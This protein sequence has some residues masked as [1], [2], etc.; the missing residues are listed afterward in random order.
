MPSGGVPGNVPP[1][2]SASQPPPG[3]GAGRPTVGIPNTGQAGGY[4]PQRGHGSGPPMPDPSTADFQRPYTARMSNANFPAGMPPTSSC[5]AA[6]ASAAR[7]SGRAGDRSMRVANNNIAGLRSYGADARRQTRAGAGSPSVGAA[8]YAVGAYGGNPPSSPS[9]N[10]GRPFGLGGGQ[11]DHGPIGHGP[12]GAGEATARV[13]SLSKQVMALESQLSSAIYAAEAARRE[14]GEAKAREEGTARRL[15]A[16]EQQVD[17][18]TE[19]A[20]LAE[21]ARR[22]AHEA[23]VREETLA[24]RLA[25]VEAQVNEVRMARGPAPRVASQWGQTGPPPNAAS[26]QRQTVAAPSAAWQSGQPAAASTRAAW[27]ARQPGGEASASWQAEPMALGRSAAANS[28]A[29]WQAKQQA[30]QAAQAELAAWSAAR[31]APAGASAGMRPWNVRMGGGPPTGR[32]F[33]G[34]EPMSSV[35]MV[36][37]MS[38][39]G[40]GMP[41][42][43]G[44]M[45]AM[46]GG[47]MGGMAMDRM[48]MG[49]M[50][51][52][53]M[54]S[55]GGGMPMIDD[56]QM[57]GLRMDELHMRTP[58]AE[59]TW[60]AEQQA[61]EEADAAWEWQALQAGMPPST[62][63]ASNPLW[64]AR[65]E[66]DLPTPL[67]RTPEQFG[68]K[69]ARM[70]QGY[71]GSSH[72][73][74]P[75]H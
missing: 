39:M 43:G 5:T 50:G 48:A 58:S 75:G 26:H 42:M 19:A 23:R 47:M 18:G 73:R 24:H 8:G 3:F 51:R 46:G 52:M 4:P 59:A 66:D 7:A 28:R 40:G 11:F 29:S 6:R 32:E 53:G 22:E 12:R 41:A 27:Q 70:Q 37:G 10:G 67:E 57:G 63:V 38:G 15:L 30:A 72:I 60:L 31:G 61:A 54:L 65:R 21:A 45:P 55:M 33:M 71:T 56:M 1:S 16:V 20:Q 2:H 35:P 36:G 44:G 49:R 68:A 17:A 14:A 9:P 34:D 25:A 69:A 64:Q 62:R 13:E 74:I